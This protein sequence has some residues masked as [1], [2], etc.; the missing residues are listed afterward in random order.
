[1][2]SDSDSSRPGSPGRFPVSAAFL[3]RYRL[4]SQLGE[5]GMGAVFS[6]FQKDLDRPVAI[7]FLH[8]RGPEFQARFTREGKILSRL[9]HPNLIAVYES[10][11]DLGRPYLVLE[12][13]RG[14]SLEQLVE[15]RGRLPLGEAL[16]LGRQIAVGLAYVHQEGVVHRDLKSANV[17][18]DP[19]GLAKI[20]D[21]GLAKTDSPQP[22]LTETGVILG[23]PAYLAPEVIHGSAASPAADLYALGCVLFELSTGRL[24]YPVRDERGAALSISEILVSH[25]SAP[26]PSV[27]S[28]RP[29]LPRGLDGLIRSCLEK[30]PVQR[31][32]SATVVAD[33]LER[34]ASGPTRAEALSR[35]RI[36]TNRFDGSTSRRVRSPG[37]PGTPTPATAGR[38]AVLAVVLVIAALT[39]AVAGWRRAVSPGTEFA[40]PAV[41]RTVLRQ[42]L[43]AAANPLLRTS[44]LERARLSRE[45]LAA[46]RALALDG[47]PD[48]EW[49]LG[50]IAGI[51]NSPTPPDEPDWLAVVARADDR[52]LTRFSRLLRDASRRTGRPNPARIE[53]L[54]ARAHW[55]AGRDE[56]ARQQVRDAIDRFESMEAHAALLE[57]GGREDAVPSAVVCEAD[58]AK[59]VYVPAGPFV[60]GTDSSDPDVDRDERPAHQVR[61]SGYFIDTY[62][63]TVGRFR[64]F[65]LWLERSQ[66]HTRCQTGSDCWK[67]ADRKIHLSS[68]LPAKTLSLPIELGGTSGTL[69]VDAECREA[70]PSQLEDPAWNERPITGVNWYDAFAFAGWA[71]KELPTEAQYEKAMRGTDQRRYPWGDAAPDRGKANHD[72]L[73]GCMLPVGRYEGVDSPYRARELAGNVWEWCADWYAEDYYRQ[74]VPGAMD[75]RGPAGGKQRSQR[76]GAWF[77]PARTLRTTNREPEVPSR[78]R[79]GC[80]GF[81]TVRT[82]RRWEPV[83]P[84]AANPGS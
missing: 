72:N 77:S 75:P 33:E 40:R 84:T 56:A 2:P 41:N 8:D 14:E 25:L 21:F 19:A 69:T 7:K 70:K 34:I 39:L 63:V 82:I 48:T 50:K 27:V 79:F 17:L 26:I 5:G 71:G 47:S 74:L 20:C 64:P 80:W 52:L 1:M 31:P 73:I 53:V 32:G 68:E 60:M 6:G 58:G 81:R 9:R 12:V 59:M 36:A 22:S 46:A 78:A 16:D 4:D 35:S 28:I 18:V 10:G 30:D 13:V 29:E 37:L 24:P 44:A 62:P 76:G 15:R 43:E 45:G 3:Q 66:D 54:L 11:F 57:M 51:L 23:T 38:R 42:R 49:V 55:L 83:R 65:H 67:S 61:L